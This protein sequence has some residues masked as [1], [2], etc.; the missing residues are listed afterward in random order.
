MLPW[1]GSG[2]H[3]SRA[4]L[5]EPGT[6]TNRGSLRKG[7]CRSVGSMTPAA[8]GRVVDAPKNTSDESTSIEGMGS[9]AIDRGEGRLRA[10]GGRFNIVVVS[11]LSLL[12]TRTADIPGKRDHQRV[13]PLF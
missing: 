11:A 9:L 10:E 7:A 8:S 12:P 3:L 13:R 1:L 2:Y 6:G 5:P 4:L